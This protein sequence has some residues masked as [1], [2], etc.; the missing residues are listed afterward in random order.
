M[1][2]CD[3]CYCDKMTK[4]VNKGGDQYLMQ[5]LQI[6]FNHFF[7]NQNLLFKVFLKSCNFPGSHQKKWEMGREIMGFPPGKS[8]EGIPI[9]R[10]TRDSDCRA[11]T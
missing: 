1:N 7:F 6:M 4:S 3:S 8:R 10:P 11:R 9:E 5:A 2:T